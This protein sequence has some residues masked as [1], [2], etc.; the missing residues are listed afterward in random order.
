MR[1][2]GAEAADGRGETDERTGEEQEKEECVI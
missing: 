2:E 1:I